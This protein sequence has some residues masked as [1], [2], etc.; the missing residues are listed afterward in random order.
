MAMAVN[1][2]RKQKKFGG[3]KNKGIKKKSHGKNKSL[4]GTAILS[5]LYESEIGGK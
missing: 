3:L 5:S 2:D 4:I 1:V